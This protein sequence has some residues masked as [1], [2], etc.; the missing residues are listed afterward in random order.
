LS[1]LGFELRALCS[2]KHTT[3]I[4]CLELKKCQVWWCMSVIPA[5]RRLRQEDQEFKASLDH[6]A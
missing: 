5:L 3:K 6:T 1:T 2:S 4:Y